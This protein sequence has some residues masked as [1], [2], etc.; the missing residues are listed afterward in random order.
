MIIEVLV[1]AAFFPALLFPL[2]YGL[3][4]P[5]WR[6]P[7]GWSVMNLSVV[8]ALSLS[9]SGW[10]VFVGPTPVAFRLVV[11]GWIVVALW[12]QLLV[13]LLSKRWN[14]RRLTRERHLTV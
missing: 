1:L 4:F 9:L 14:E 13:L 7:V 2:I 11:F 6:N 5:W 3:W 8:I 12:G 10:R